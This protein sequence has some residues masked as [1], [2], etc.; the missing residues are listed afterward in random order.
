MGIV[1]WLGWHTHGC[2]N[3]A[4]GGVVVDREGPGQLLGFKEQVIMRHVRESGR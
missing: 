4:C 3:D 1:S 2:W